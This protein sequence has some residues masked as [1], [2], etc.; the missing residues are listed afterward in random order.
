M[1]DNTDCPSCQD[2]PGTPVPGQE[3]V[4]AFAMPMPPD[5]QLTPW[6][7]MQPAAKPVRTPNSAAQSPRPEGLF[8]YDA[9]PAAASATAAQPRV[10]YLAP[11]NAPGHQ[12]PI[13][14]HIS[15]PDAMASV[16]HDVDDPSVTYLPPLGVPWIQTANN[17]E[18]DDTPAEPTIDDILADARRRLEN[19][20]EDVAA[21]Q[22]ADEVVKDTDKDA[23][24]QEV[25]SEVFRHPKLGGDIT[26]EPTPEEPCGDSI[27]RQVLTSEFIRTYELGRHVVSTWREYDAR[28]P[29][30]WRQNEAGDY[31]WDE[32]KKKR[33]AADEACDLLSNKVQSRLD[34]DKDFGKEGVARKIAEWLAIN[35]VPKAWL[36][37]YVDGLAS[38]VQCPPDCDKSYNYHPIR[39]GYSKI[40]F[41]IARCEHECERIDDE[42]ATYE[43]GTPV[44]DNKGFQ[45]FSQ[46]NECR[47]YLRVFLQ[48][49]FHIAGVVEIKCVERR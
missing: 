22:H 35:G 45:V 28:E 8:D 38:R 39:I 48:I 32:A 33:K 43:D 44:L 29:R 4:Y 10:E 19:A 31:V 46:I 30:T 20:L 41:A 42:L 49:K 34:R 15:P 16:I 3:D 14:Q 47:I 37:G 21:G 2:L 12:R 27:K 40:G 5:D 36:D 11:L 6:Q 23:D 9:A 18:S 17:D 13:Q 1:A 25:L 26:I 24:I 7:A